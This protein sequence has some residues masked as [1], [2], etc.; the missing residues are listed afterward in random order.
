MDSLQ[1]HLLSRGGTFC[2]H[3]GSMLYLMVLRLSALSQF[4]SLTEIFTG[5]HASLQV[6]FGAFEN[7]SC[8]WEESRVEWKKS[9]LTEKQGRPR[10]NP[11]SQ[12]TLA[13]CEASPGPGF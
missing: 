11:T 13:L 2:C 4:M 3:I 6:R 10:L 12:A 8:L 5:Q 1:S 9:Y 7:I